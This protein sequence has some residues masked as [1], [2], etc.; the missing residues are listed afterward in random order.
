MDRNEF[1]AGQN[2]CLFKVIALRLDLFDGDALGTISRAVSRICARE[3]GLPLDSV[4]SD[5]VG[6]RLC[7]LICRRHD[8]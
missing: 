1:I 6:G 7:E 3:V 2:C 4:E 5:L 8:E